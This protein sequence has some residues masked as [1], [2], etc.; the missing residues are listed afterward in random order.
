MR[1]TGSLNNSKAL[2]VRDLS[3]F[4]G[5]VKK[6]KKKTRLCKRSIFSKGIATYSTRVFGLLSAFTSLCVAVCCF[7]RCEAFLLDVLHAMSF[8]VIINREEGCNNVFQLGRS[9]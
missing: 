5:T 7:V 9:T 2:L 8:G 4:R 3:I 6:K 1:V